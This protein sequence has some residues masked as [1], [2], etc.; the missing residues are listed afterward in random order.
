MTNIYSSFCS[1]RGL[2]GYSAWRWRQQGPLK[3][4]YPTTKLHSVITQKTAT[5]IFAVVKN[6]SLSICAH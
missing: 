4:R 5:S 6:S 1:R 3:R 2:L